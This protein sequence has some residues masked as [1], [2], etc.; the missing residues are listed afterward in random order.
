MEKFEEATLKATEEVLHKL[1]IIE[2]KGIFAVMS[3][4]EIPVEK[5]PT[6]WGESA[7]KLPQLR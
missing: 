5:S 1:R 6:F 3:F 2:M 7:V 4:E